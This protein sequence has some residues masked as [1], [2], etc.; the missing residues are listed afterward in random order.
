MK[1]TSSL[2]NDLRK[3]IRQQIKNFRFLFLA[4]GLSLI[5]NIEY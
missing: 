3:Y 1:K 5:K 2:E 4:S